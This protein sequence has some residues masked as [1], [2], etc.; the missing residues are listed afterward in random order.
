MNFK[1]NQGF[2]LVE[3]AIVLVVVGLLLGSILGPLSAQQKNKNIKKTEQLLNEIHDAIIGYSA[4]NGFLPCPAT[5]ASN[6]LES[7]TAGAGSSCTTE[8]GFVPAVTLS[9]NGQFDSNQQLIDYWA[10]PIRYSLSDVNAWQFATGLSL[11]NQTSPF[12]VCTNSTCTVGNVVAQS[13]VAVIFSVGPDRNIYNS[14]D[15]LENL[16]ADN[17]FIS[18]FPTELTGSEFDDIVSWISPNLL[19]LQFIQTNL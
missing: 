19:M 9:I 14:A 6:G 16:D 10:S 12:N 4:I 3:L 8:H 5:A 17:V 18:K 11:N 2:T 13:V 1:N 15:Q 7:R